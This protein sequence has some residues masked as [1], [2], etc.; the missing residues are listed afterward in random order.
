[1]M[2]GQLS[3][4]DK[5]QII[6]RICEAEEVEH[7]KE[8]AN[9]ADYALA[10]AL[11]EELRLKLGVETTSFT[12]LNFIRIED[13]ACVD[14][15]IPYLWRFQNAGFA[16]DLITQ[17]FWRK[18]NRA[19]SDFLEEWT[20][21]CIENDKMRGSMETTLDNAFIHVQDKRKAQ[22]YVELLREGY[23]FPFTMEMLGR[24]RIPEA[25]SVILDRINS[26]VY[27][28][29]QNAVRALGGYKDPQF[30]PLFN[31]LLGDGSPAIRKAAATAIR[32]I[33]RELAKRKYEF[34][35]GE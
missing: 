21:H 26:P 1:M 16:Q 12:H 14:I 11:R 6:Y 23:D 27:L 29:P 25:V 18:G 33:E 17:H 10:D 15:I 20:R 19:C 34:K 30:L 3:E 9:A 31:E 28:L 8:A 2:D 13:D 22:F 4:A 24:W 32:R 7:R 5:S 35:A